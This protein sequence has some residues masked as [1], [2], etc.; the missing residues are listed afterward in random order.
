MSCFSGSGYLVARLGNEASR[1]LGSD[2]AHGRLSSRQATPGLFQRAR[3]RRPDAGES[4]IGGDVMQRG[5]LEVD[6]CG[7]IS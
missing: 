1:G 4:A 3:F 7:G 6:G 2:R 5:A